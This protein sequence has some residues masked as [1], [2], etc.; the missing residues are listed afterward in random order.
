MFVKAVFFLSLLLLSS[1]NFIAS[2][3]FDDGEYS[4]VGLESEKV[5]LVFSHNISGET[6]PCGCRTFPLGGLPQLYGQFSEI[7][8]DGTSLYYVDSGD[9]FFPA[10]RLAI[11]ME[12]S[13]KFA[14]KNLAKGLAKLGLKYH[15]PG[16]Q[17]FS[18]GHDFY[19]EILSESGLKMLVA[20]ASEKNKIPHKKWIVLER[21][22]HKVFIIGLTDP[23]LLLPESAGYYSEPEAA[24]KLALDEVKKAGFKENDPFHRLILLS[25]SSYEQDE[26][27]AKKF[28]TFDWIV[29]SHSQ[30]FTRKPLLEGKTKIVQVLSQNHYLGEIK[31]S[32]TGSKEKD[33]YMLHEIHESLAQKVQPNPYEA[34]IQEHKTKMA[35]L[36]TLE[37][38]DQKLVHSE[39]MPPFV[40]AKTCIECHQ[41][42]ADKW[43]STPHSIAYATLINAKEE[44]NL[45][46]VECH[47]LGLGDERGFTNT[48]DMTTFEDDK[49]RD[50]YWKEVTKA[51]AGIDSIRKLPAKRIEK[52]SKQWLELDEKHGV[53][54]QMANVQCLN[55]HDQHPDHPFH[56]NQNRPNRAQKLSA[57]KDKCL[58]CHNADQS[59]EWYINDENGLPTRINHESLEA[60]IKAVGCPVAD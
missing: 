47:S 30:K 43:H 39:K 4:V 19:A 42:Q 22:P 20:N 40:T 41:D 27:W 46:C 21:G 1:C 23:K 31:I 55:C 16:D 44:K 53:T 25:H 49:K 52:L 33:S 45:T 28:P 6:H 36:Q 26:I 54:R 12:Q 2:K 15:V 5:S 37:Q 48:I 9:T 58:S 50:Q 56:V 8:K 57:M 3:L 24:L 17:D 10:N 18:A 60:K 59:P 51:F 34:F 32:M 14:A 38:K 7:Q 13:Q 29:G 11:G 35:A